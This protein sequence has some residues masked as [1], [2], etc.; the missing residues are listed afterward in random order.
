MNGRDDVEAEPSLLLNIYERRFVC[1][2]ILDL[3]SEGI[4]FRH[5]LL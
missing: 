1:C 3:Y 5:W 2:N 4:P